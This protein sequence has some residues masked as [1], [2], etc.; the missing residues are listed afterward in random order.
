MPWWTQTSKPQKG[1]F[2]LNLKGAYEED[3]IYSGIPSKMIEI[4]QISNFESIGS[5]RMAKW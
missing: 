4:C 3:Q 2:D 1:G 5:I